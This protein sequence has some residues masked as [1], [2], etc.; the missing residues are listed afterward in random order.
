MGIIY[1]VVF[2]NERPEL[3][4]DPERCPLDLAAL[5]TDCWHPE[6]KHRPST[7]EIIKALTLIIKM[8]ERARQLQVQQGQ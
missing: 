4:H 6:P 5:I 7:G 2:K 8:R 3:P 1:S